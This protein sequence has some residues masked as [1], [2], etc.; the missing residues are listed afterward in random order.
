VTEL[1]EP[2]SDVSP[3]RQVEAQP[4]GVTGHPPTFAELVYAHHDWWRAR[5]AGKPDDHQDRAH[6]LD[7]DACDR[8]VHRPG[9][10]RADG[11]EKHAE[12][13][14]HDDS[15]FRAGCACSSAYAIDRRNDFTIDTGHVQQ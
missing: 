3:V 7:V 10:N 11:D 9:E 4:R 15:V 13:D 12:S 14:A 5:Q 1:I 6:D 2:M 8:H